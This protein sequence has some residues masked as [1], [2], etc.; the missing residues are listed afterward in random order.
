MTMG[1]GPA[2]GPASDWADRMRS[3]AGHA[4]RAAPNLVTDS[5][6]LIAAASVLVA[7]A[8]GW[9]YALLIAVRH[10]PGLTGQQRA[11]DLFSIGSVD[12]SAIVLLGAGLVAVGRRLELGRSDQPPEVVVTGLILT[13]LLVAAALTVAAALCGVLVELT[14][15]GH[16]I[17]AA[18]SG[19]IARLAAIPMAAAAGWW[20]WHQREELRPPG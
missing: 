3:L 19:L 12:W 8:F 1:A 17:D 14:N 5:L 10:Q 2:Q 18:F 15:F 11:L 13:G 4:R 9:L 16:G 20:V 7:Y 6:F